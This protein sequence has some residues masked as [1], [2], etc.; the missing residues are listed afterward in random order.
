MSG[1][2][3]Q[4][5]RDKCIQSCTSEEEVVPPSERLAES[6]FQQTEEMELNAAATTQTQGELNQFETSTQDA[7]SQQVHVKSEPADMEQQEQVEAPDPELTVKAEKAADLDSPTSAGIEAKSPT[8]SRLQPL[9]YSSVQRRAVPISPKPY[10][11]SVCQKTFRSVQILH[12]HTLT[13]HSRPKIKSPM[14]GRGRGRGRGK[15]HGSQY[16]RH[17]QESQE[18]LEPRG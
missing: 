10:Q 9:M 13:F 14:S 17:Q 2:T 11:C 18:H 12:K 6:G 7:N 3:G 8:I 15:G 16:F 4:P 5:L 1:E